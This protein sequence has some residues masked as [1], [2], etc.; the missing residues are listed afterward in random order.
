MKTFDA[1]HNGP[2]Y[3]DELNL[4]FTGLYLWVAD[5]CVTSWAPRFKM[6]VKGS[7]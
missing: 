6:L 5:D 1:W 2:F 4:I 3:N 7:K